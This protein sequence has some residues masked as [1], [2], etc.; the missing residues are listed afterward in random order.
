MIDAM[1]IY[2]ELWSSRRSVCQ[3]VGE[4][5]L[6]VYKVDNPAHHHHHHHFA[7]L[8]FICTT[9]INIII[10]VRDAEGKRRDFFYDAWKIKEI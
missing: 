10:F 9:T 1:M 2:C 6:S 4:P 5:L 8:L 7:C 3:S